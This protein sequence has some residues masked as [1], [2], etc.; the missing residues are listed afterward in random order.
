MFIDI[1]G[2]SMLWESHQWKALYALRE[3][4]G[5]IHRIGIPVYPD[6]GERLFVHH[7]GDA[8][9]ADSSRSFIPSRSGAC[10]G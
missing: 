9:W 4:M 3:L 1:L 10:F 8:A 6:H 7:M 5:A 2:F